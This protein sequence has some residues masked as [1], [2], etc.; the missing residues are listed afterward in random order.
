MSFEIG[1]PTNLTFLLKSDDRGAGKILTQSMVED[2]LKQHAGEYLVVNIQTI[3]G[4]TSQ[5]IRGRYFV[6]IV[7]PMQLIFRKSGEYK[8]VTQ[9]HHY[10][11]EQN[12]DMIK[13]SG[14]IKSLRTDCCDQD[15]W[16]HSIFCL[17]FVA[18]NFGINLD[19]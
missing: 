15:L 5:N 4:N 13:D 10:L 19:F 7:K 8:T 17:Q 16:N 14:K 2:F 3:K 12:P 6:A 11:M 1:K 9:T 18:E